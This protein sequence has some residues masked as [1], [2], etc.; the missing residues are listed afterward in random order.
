MSVFQDRLKYGEAAELIIKMH[1]A[2][3]K[4]I[5]R[6]TYYQITKERPGSAPFW[7]EV[8]L[9]QTVSTCLSL[10]MGDPISLNQRCWHLDA[11]TWL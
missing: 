5:A 4:I 1:K 8:T 7:S 2:R 3:A 9:V 6:V 10:Q 11:D